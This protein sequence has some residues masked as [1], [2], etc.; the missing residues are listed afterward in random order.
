[1]S[2]I[3]NILNFDF[4]CVELKDLEIEQLKNKVIEIEKK[5]EGEHELFKNKIVE[6]I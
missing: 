6:E 3:T 5:K 4:K 1:M 2:E